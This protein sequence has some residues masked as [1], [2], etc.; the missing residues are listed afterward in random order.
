MSHSDLKRLFLRFEESFKNS[1]NQ[2]VIDFI[3]TKGNDLT[4][5]TTFQ[6]ADFLNSIEDYEIE[7]FTRKQ[8]ICFACITNT[9]LHVTWEYHL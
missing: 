9:I 7:K 3:A 4:T 1:Q 5:L 8:L 2:K 6:F